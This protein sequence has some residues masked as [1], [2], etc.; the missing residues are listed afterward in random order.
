MTSYEQIKNPKTGRK[1][2]LYGDTYNKLI[3]NNEYTNDYLLSLPR[4]KTSKLHKSPEVLQNSQKISVNDTSDFI[5]NQLTGN[6][7]TDYIILNQLDDEDLYHFCQTNKNLNNLCKSNKIL[8][9]RVKI[10]S[11]LLNNFKSYTI[12]LAIINMEEHNTG[13]GNKEKGISRKGIKL[14]L[15]LNFLVTPKIPWVNTVIQCLVDQNQLIRNEKN[16]EHFTL[17]IQLR[18]KIEKMRNIITFKNYK[19]FVKN[20]EV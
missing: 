8:F 19:K 16:K 3:N 2:N 13:F 6:A 7:D 10:Y 15:S 18:N 11:D 4:Y 5:L 17:S 9:D 1:I 12:A 20:D 14:Y